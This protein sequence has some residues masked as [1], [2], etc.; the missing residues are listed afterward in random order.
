MAS[1]PVRLSA[2]TRAFPA[3]GCRPPAGSKVCPTSAVPYGW[4]RSANI[5]WRTNIFHQVALLERDDRRVALAVLTSG[6]GHD[7]GRVTQAG[8]AARVL[9][10]PPRRPVAGGA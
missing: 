7:Y 8:I 10:R 6:T 1:W 5:G 2:W 4:R 3:D 9:S